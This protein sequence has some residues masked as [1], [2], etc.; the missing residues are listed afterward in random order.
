MR[1]PETKN[2]YEIHLTEFAGLT[3]N[4]EKIIE[5]TNLPIK[6]NFFSKKTMFRGVY[7][8]S[9]KE[10]N[11]CMLPGG[12]CERNPKSLKKIIRTSNQLVRT[13]IIQKKDV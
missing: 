10:P 11:I 3:Q 9:G 7:L 5:T 8:K 2:S 6:T 12:I 1:T 4:H 13:K